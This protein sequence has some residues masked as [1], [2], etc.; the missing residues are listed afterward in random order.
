[1]PIKHRLLA[2][3]VAAMW[4]LNFL[5]IHL[6]LG[7]FPPL[8]LVALRFA[9]IAIPTVAVVPRPAVALRWLIGYGLG[10]GTMQ[11]LFLYWGMSAGMPTG[12]ASLVLQASAPLTLILGATVLRE[13]ITGAQIAGILLA[14]GGLAL[15][16]LHRAEVASV[17]P[18]LLTLA[19]ALGWAIGNLCARQAA[20]PNPL[21]LTLWMTVIPPVPML[22][23][24]VF[25]EGPS[26]VGHSLATMFTTS[27]VPALLGLAYTI[28]IGTILASGIW[29]WLMARHPAGVVAPFSLL[30]P[31]VGMS[32][33][34]LLLGEQLTGYDITGAAIVIAG[35]LLG[36]F[37]KRRKN[38]A[39]AG[40]GSHTTPTTMPSATTESGSNQLARNTLR[41]KSSHPPHVL[42]QPNRACPVIDRGAN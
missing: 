2:A 17:V 3:S 21:H 36:S 7:H 20:P 32:A 40:Q 5:A 13:R 42:T 31:V 1:M 8:F 12:L 35:V 25:I 33:S 14:V 39:R 15:V 24:S 11:F 27:A 34:W 16:G 4:G 23:L 30:V 22:A 29:V 9:L 41:R 37:N 38:Q 19:G 18:F 6:S 26:R 10:F 28:V